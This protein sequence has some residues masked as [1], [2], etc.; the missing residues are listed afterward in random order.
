[1]GNYYNKKHLEHP[2]FEE[3][4][5]VML[6]GRNIRTKRPSKQLAPKKYGPFKILKKIGTMTY[7]LELHSRWRI[8]KVFHVSVTNM[9]DTSIQDQVIWTLP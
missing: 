9:K 1:M 4:D 5:L 3:G 7:R 2:T 8:H 6:D